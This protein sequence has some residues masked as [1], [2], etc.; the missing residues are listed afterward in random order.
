M[1]GTQHPLA[2]YQTRYPVEIDV[3]V[4]GPLG[5]SAEDLLM[6]MSIIVGVPS[7]QRKVIQIRLP[8]PGKHALSNFKAGVWIDDPL[9]PPDDG[10]GSVISRFIDRLAET[11]VAL[12]DRKPDID[13]KESHDLRTMF[14][15][16]TM[17]FTQ[18]KDLYQQAVSFRGRGKDDVDLWAKAME[19]GLVTSNENMRDDVSLWINAMTIPRSQTG[20]SGSI[21]RSCRIMTRCFPAIR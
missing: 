10:V 15:A 12:S 7:Y 20:P 9:F 4:N 8:K 13:L 1:Y 21:T 16:A 2:A 11:G 18:P 3:T 19:L 5:R 17:S 14:E 6:A